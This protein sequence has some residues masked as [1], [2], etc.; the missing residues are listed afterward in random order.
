MIKYLPRKISRSLNVKKSVFKRISEAL[1]LIDYSICKVFI[2]ERLARSLPIMT[3][4]FKRI[5]EITKIGNSIF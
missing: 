1:S 4:F 5:V 2:K 3:I